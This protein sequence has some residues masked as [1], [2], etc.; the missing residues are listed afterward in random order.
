MK[1]PSGCVYKVYK[2]HKCVSFLDLGPIP[3][4]SKYA[5]A[6]I[7]KSEQRLKSET[8]FVPRM[9]GEDA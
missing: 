6:N 8:F 5:F 1:L 7:P 9:S 2:K 4:I 3:R